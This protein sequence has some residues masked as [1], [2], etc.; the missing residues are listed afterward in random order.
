[1]FIIESLLWVSRLMKSQVMRFHLS[2]VFCGQQRGWSSS[3]SSLKAQSENN[4]DKSACISCVIL[5][6]GAWEKGIGC[7]NQLKS[8]VLVCDFVPYQPS[9]QQ[10]SF[11]QWKNKA[12]NIYMCCFFL[13]GG[14]L[15]GFGY[16]FGSWLL[17][18][19]CH[20][21][22]GCFLILFLGVTGREEAIRVST[23]P[24]LSFFIS[25]LLQ[26]NSLCYIH[27]V[28]D[29]PQW[30]FT[31]SDHNLACLL[32]ISLDPWAVSRQAGYGHLCCF[33]SLNAFSLSIGFGNKENFCVVLG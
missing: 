19:E 25:S 31:C 23:P 2:C 13:V 7:R 1:M 3:S 18:V 17:S 8:V 9:S 32:Q 4:R 5:A 22:T 29:L 10:T 14:L 20:L 24:H 28:V 15:Q 30:E 6:K 33:G 21:K 12:L 16:C 27:M 11:I 26:K